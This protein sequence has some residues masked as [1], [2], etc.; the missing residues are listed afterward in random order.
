MRSRPLILIAEDH[1]DTRRV[2]CIILRHYGYDVEEARSGLEAVELARAL[3]PQL[4]LMDI[5]L[6]VLDGWQASRLLKADPLTAGVP[7]IAFSASVDSTA[8]LGGRATFDGYILKPIS[9]SELVRRVNAYMRL[10]G[11]RRPSNVQES[12][13]SDGY[14]DPDAETELTT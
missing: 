5:G 2:Y 14:E 8:D 12:E 9:P 6:P 11:V 10:L 1:E 3:Q 13:Y 4:V 7:V